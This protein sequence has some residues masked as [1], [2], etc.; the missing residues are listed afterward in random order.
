MSPCRTVL[1]ARASN[2]RMCIKHKDV[3]E[4]QS[5]CQSA[6]GQMPTIGSPG[7]ACTWPGL[8]GWRRLL[9]T[10]SLPILCR[11]QYVGILHQLP[12]G[13]QTPD[14]ELLLSDCL[15]AHA[16]AAMIADSATLS[17]MLAAMLPAV[18][19]G[20]SVTALR[21]PWPSAKPLG[22]GLQ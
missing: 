16:K 19:R 6:P 15:E 8:M 4:V 9:L 13:A 22:A 2:T 12:P 5:I 7:S 10:C 1:G 20:E 17:E 14:L 21:Q 18:L 11:V 3:N